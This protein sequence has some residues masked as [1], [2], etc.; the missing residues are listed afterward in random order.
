MNLKIILLLLLMLNHL[1]I[2][3]IE[4]EHKIAQVSLVFLNVLIDQV[5]DQNLPIHTHFAVVEEVGVGVGAVVVAVVVV[6]SDVVVKVVVEIIVW[7]TYYVVVDDVS[8]VVVVMKEELMAVTI[9]EVMYY[10]YSQMKKPMK[11]NLYDQIMIQV[12]KIDVLKRWVAKSFCFPLIDFLDMVLKITESCFVAVEVEEVEV[13]EI[14]NVE[15]D[16]VDDMMVDDKS[17]QITMLVQEE[18]Q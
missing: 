17:Y 7:E 9:K 14:V 3:L 5:L 13:E 8:V 10:W 12:D 18:R 15:F 11:L 2:E 16:I 1:M 4:K 6:I